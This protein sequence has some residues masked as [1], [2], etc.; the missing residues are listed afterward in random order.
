M[1]II[2]GLGNPGKKYETTR[3]NVGFLALDRLIKKTRN[4]ESKKSKE[5]D[6]KYPNIPISQYSDF[7]LDNKFNA[8]I[9]KL[10]MGESDILLVQPQTFMNLSGETVKKIVDFYKIDPKQDLIVVHDDI[11]IVL[12]KAK[13]ASRGS[14]A[15]H[16][17]IQSII[18]NI[19]S[20]S[21][22]RARIGVGRPANSEIKVEDWVLQK[23]SSEELEILYKVIDELI[24]RGIKYIA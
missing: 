4:Q 2:V 11:D 8:Q 24:E 9:A 21:F 3:H 15:G 7:K 10:K 19:G 18:D 23:F 22:V 16:K 1:K 6:E 20:E 17:G 14:S 5:E 13:L 12:G